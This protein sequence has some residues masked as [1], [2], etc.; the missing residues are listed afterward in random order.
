MFIRLKNNFWPL[1]VALLLYLGLTFVNPL[2]DHHSFY[3]LEPYPDGLFYILPA[4]NVVHG[5]NFVVSRMNSDVVAQTGPLYSLVLVIG[6]L[7]H[8]FPPMF[9]WVNVGLGIISITGIYSLCRTLKLSQ[10]ATAITLVTYLSHTFILWLPSLPMAENLGLALFVWALWGVLQPINWKIT[11]ITSLIISGLVFTKYTY[12]GPAIV[13][14]SWYSW[15]LSK[16][17]SKSN[18]LLAI[19]WWLTSGI[20]FALVQFIPQLVTLS[21]S[22]PDT[23]TSANQFVFYSLSY[24]LPNTYAYISGLV[25]I[26][27]PFLWQQQPLSNLGLVILSC[28]GYF[29][30]FDNKTW[31]R[32]LFIT[33]FLSQFP[34]L[35][36]FY[37]TDAR[38]A[39]LSTPL[40]ALG[41]GLFTSDILKEKWKIMLSLLFCVV[42][43][44]QQRMLLKEILA[45]NWLNRSRAWQ[46]ESIKFFNQTFSEQPGS[47]LITALPPFLFD[48]YGMGQYQ[49]L[50]LSSE[51]EFLDKGQ[52]IWGNEVIPNQLVDYYHYLLKTGQAVFVTNAYLSA[53]APF[54]YDFGALAEHFQLEQIMQGCENTCT[55]YRLHLK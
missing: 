7:I 35:L 50:P 41:I 8:R 14:A 37:V 46:Y 43:I 20:L 49:V 21:V 9:Y 18:L 10:L 51:Q 40:I 33:I 22:S 1:V 17:P 28:V 29:K 38:Y 55:V 54:K 19:L 32:W 2:S 4:W 47:Y 13:F 42:L 12:I 44:G 5:Q 15:K 34:L 53:E 48:L 16:I 6:Y 31:T 27:I 23:V 24:V 26:A 45:S 25:G 36:V 52:L 39:L 30:R 3:N 11:T